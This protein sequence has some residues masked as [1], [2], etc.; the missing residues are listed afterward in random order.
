MKTKLRSLLFSLL[1]ATLSAA[2]A[3]AQTATPVTAADP[4]SALPDSDLVIYAD[5]R[6]MMTELA[7]A[8]WPTT[9]R[10]SPR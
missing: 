7:H 6:R 1:L 8:F 4:L 5:M 10:C 9:P 2:A 3:A